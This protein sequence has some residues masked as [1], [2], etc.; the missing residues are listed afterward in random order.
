MSTENV[1]VTIRQDTG[2]PIVSGPDPEDRVTWGK[3][4]A[5]GCGDVSCNVVYGLVGTLLTLFYTDYAGISIMAVG[6]VLLISRIFDGI[7]D[8]VI[9][10]IVDKT[11]S[12]YGKARPWLL[13]M[14]L[15]YVISAFAL[16]TVPQSSDSVKFWYIFVTYNACTVIYTALNVPYGT[17]SS[18]MTRNSR[19]RDILSVVRQSMSPLGRMVV[20][21]LTLPL[22]KLMGDNQS[23][24]V[25]T[26]GIWCVMAMVML[27][28]CFKNC[29]ETVKIH[30]TDQGLSIARQLKALFTNIYFWAV[31]VLWTVTC[32]HATIVGMILPYYSKYI[33]QN[34]GWMYSMLYFIEMAF[35][36]IGAAISPFLTKR[37]SKRD[38]ALV[39][40]AVV[41]G[42]QLLFMLNPT[43]FYWA[44][45]IG[46]IRTLGCAPLTALIFGMMCDVIE[47]GHWKTNIRQESLVF[48]IGS[49]GFKI[50]TGVIGAVISML[51][52]SKGYVSSTQG[53]IAQSKEVTDMIVHIFEF[54]PIVIWAVA[55]IILL[56]Y[57]LDKIYPSIMKDLKEREAVYE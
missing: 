26:I 33:L 13:W 51:L 10:F 45:I 5:Y 31:M 48:G 14:M 11:K 34:D 2:Q 1:S 37:V 27:F 18:L 12:K 28:I 6:T 49:L 42:S 47:Y 56:F 50:G 19:E 4:I 16:F 39:G 52:Q 29:E 22:V 8:L 46:V 36:I 54:G 7:T 32:M 38:L 35:L 55:L 25:I 23:A 3:R 43:S 17:L 24:W 40:C 57:K 53:G 30:N 41:I 21:S 9:G 15:P 44:L 20:V